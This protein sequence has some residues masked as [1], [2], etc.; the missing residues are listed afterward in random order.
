MKPPPDE[1]Q[2]PTPRTGQT[3]KQQWRPYIHTGGFN[4]PFAA[5][6]Q[7]AVKALSYPRDNIG[8]RPSTATN[9]LLNMFDGCQPE[10]S[11]II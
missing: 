1:S 7:A 4:R 8:G 2:V 11:P 10:P 6:R 5:D 9:G 3:S